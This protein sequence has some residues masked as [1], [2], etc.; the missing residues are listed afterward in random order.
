M[1]VPGLRNKLRGVVLGGDLADW[2][3]LVWSATQGGLC[4]GRVGLAILPIGSNL[5]FDFLVVLGL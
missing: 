2:I 4:G 3:W 5:S 1:V